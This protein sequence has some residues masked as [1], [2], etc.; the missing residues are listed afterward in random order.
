[1]VPTMQAADS[2]QSEHSLSAEVVDLRTISPLDFPTILASVQKTGRLVVVHEAPR[3]LGVGA[4]IAATVADRALDSLKAP[5]KRVA[6][7]DVEVPL[8]RL[9][10]FYIPNKDRILKAAL[11][12]VSY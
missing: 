4:E 2:L 11:D 3:N 1:M 5:I 6:G 8:A 9:E 12:A 10:D 7:F